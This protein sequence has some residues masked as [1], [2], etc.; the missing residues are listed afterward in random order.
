MSE[1]RSVM[2]TGDTWLVCRWRRLVLHLWVQSERRL[3]ERSNIAHGSR[4]SRME[5]AQGSSLA[6]VLSFLEEPRLFAIFK[7][8]CHVWLS[9]LVEHVLYIE[10]AILLAWFHALLSQIVVIWCLAQLFQEQRALLPLFFHILWLV[11]RDERHE[12][13]DLLLENSRSSLLSELHDASLNQCLGLAW[14]RTCFLNL[15]LLLRLLTFWS[16]RTFEQGLGLRHGRHVHWFLA[17]EQ[18]SVFHSW[19]LQEFISLRMRSIASVVIRFMLF[20]FE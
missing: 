15:R 17:Q 9:F 18:G 1:R 6:V 4:V 10:I 12:A 19:A 7:L 2:L 13:G 16:D 11:A 20:F 3:L 14:D 8:C 5:L